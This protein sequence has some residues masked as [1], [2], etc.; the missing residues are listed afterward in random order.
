[1]KISELHNAPQ[2]LLDANTNNADVELNDGVVVWRGGDWWGG[3]WRGGV[4]RGGDWWGGVWRG[5][6]C[7]CN[8]I[9]VCGLKWQ[10]T[11]S[12]SRMQIGCELHSFAEW[13]EFDDARIVKMDR[14]AVKFWRAH[15]DALL[16]LC[17]LRTVKAL[18]AA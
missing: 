9:N 18:E 17:A 10:V 1:M 7:A 13:R 2:W 8:L 15:R 11:I 5:E 12:D 16:T 6:K 3:D 4:W 14:G